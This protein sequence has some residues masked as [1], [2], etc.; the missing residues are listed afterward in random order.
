M[1]MWLDAQKAFVEH[2]RQRMAETQRHDCFAL[3]LLVKALRMLFGL[4]QSFLL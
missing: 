4:W 3:L 1:E 2:K